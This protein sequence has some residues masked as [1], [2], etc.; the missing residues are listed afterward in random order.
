VGEMTE[1]LLKGLQSSCGSPYPNDRRFF[2][3]QNV[4]P[5]KDTSSQRATSQQLLKGLQSSCG[6]P[7]PNDGQFFLKQNVSPTPQ[8]T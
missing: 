2:L 5:K 3:K 7:Y 8:F 6:S 1:Q 4:S